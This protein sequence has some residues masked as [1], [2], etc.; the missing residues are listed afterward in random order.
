MA[1]LRTFQFASDLRLKWKPSPLAQQ[2]PCPR[3]DQAMEEAF[4]LWG[5]PLRRGSESVPRHWRDLEKKE[6]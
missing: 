5:R 4:A 6:S 1:P 2:V 3:R